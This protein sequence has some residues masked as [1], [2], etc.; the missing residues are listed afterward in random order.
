MEARIEARTQVLPQASWRLTGILYLI[1]AG[2]ACR[3]LPLPALARSLLALPTVL[4]LPH[5]LG[6]LLLRLAGG[7]VRGLPAS[8]GPVCEALIGWWAGLVSLA[9]LANALQHLGLFVVLRAL[10]WLVLGLLALDTLLAL[11]R[12]AGW[13]RPDVHA[14]LGALRGQWPVL[15]A[16]LLGLPPLWIHKRALPFPLFMR[17]SFTLANMV[18]QPV[19]RLLRDGYL[20]FEPSHK[21][22]S[23][24]LVFLPSALCDVDP[25]A[26]A[27]SLPILQVG[28]FALG[29]YLWAYELSRDKLVAALAPLFGGFVFAAGPLF[30]TT[31]VVFRSNSVQLALLPLTLLAIHRYTAQRPAGKGL[32]LPAALSALGVVGAFAAVHSDKLFWLGRLASLHPGEDPVRLLHLYGVEWSARTA[33]VVGWLALPAVWLARSLLKRDNPHRDLI[34]LLAL[35][36]AFQFQLHAWEA[37]IFVGIAWA[38]L[39]AFYLLGRRSRYPFV[40]LGLLGLGL[41]WVLQ[42]KGLLSFD[43]TGPLFALLFYWVSASPETPRVI[44]LVEVLRNAHAPLILGLWAVGTAG[45]ALQRTRAGL[46]VV[47]MSAVGLAVYL[48]PEPN[49]IR[50]YK[51]LVPLAAYTLAWIVARC[52]RAIARWPRRVARPLGLLAFAVAL[53]WVA[54]ELA[55]PFHAYYT[56]SQ[57]GQRYASYMADYEELTLAWLREN[58]P[59]NARLVSDPHS[60]HLFSELTNS[61]D[62]LEHA[63]TTTEMSEVGQEQVRA[64]KYD[65]LLAKDSRSAYLA[66][67][68]LLDDGLSFRNRDYAPAAGPQRA[69]RAASEPC[70]LVLIGGKTSQWMGEREIEAILDP[71]LEPVE[72]AYVAPFRDLRYFRLLYQVD[73]RMLVFAARKYDEPAAGTAR[74]WVEQGNVRWFEGREEEA[75]GLYEQALALDPQEVEAY[76][77]LG[78]AYRSRG[79]WEVAAQALEQAA[80]LAP[81]D[82]DVY[83]V[84]GDVYLAWNE[85]PTSRVGAIQAYRHAIELRPDNPGLSAGLGD[86]YRALGDVEGACQAYARAAQSPYGLAESRVAWGN[87]ARSRGRPACA[88]QAYREALAVDPRLALAYHGLAQ[89]YRAEGRIDEAVEAYQAL[90]AL[91]PYQEEW[92]DELAQLYRD[93]G[94]PEAAVALYKDA[95]QRYPGAVAFYL[96][97][98]ELYLSLAGP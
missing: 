29:L 30:E 23:Y 44:D 77:A 69:L 34:P 65:V 60:A 85:R 5:Q 9:A 42:Y 1:A 72:P 80:R 89:L 28:A 41:L 50:A 79:E 14:A 81:E 52:C 67:R 91:D 78:E 35:L 43:G 84:L 3:L 57:P 31:P 51:V 62:L 46:L 37:P 49:G 54:W 4:I 21:A 66:L 20:T 15:A 61:I 75:I 22:G 2:L 86:A 33:A 38:Y 10:P 36:T 39:L 94:R 8:L 53:G 18:Y 32:P 90:V 73:D 76:V 68:G 88:E 58:L 56:R 12:G 55:Q 45:L 6:R 64:I 92:Y 74:H 16:L 87:L 25:L 98:G 13:A 47:L 48:S 26:M 93:Q 17:N 59:E 97:L 27:W 83:R 96:A 71:V 19:V 70:L 63:M 24:L 95:V 7:W 11:A 82:A 40:Y